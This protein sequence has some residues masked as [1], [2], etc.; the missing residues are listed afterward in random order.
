MC[1][2]A[3]II[4]LSKNSIPTHP[5]QVSILQK[6]LFSRGP[7]ASGLWQSTER[8]L[9]LVVQRLATKDARK[10][11]NQPCWSTDKKIISIFNGEIYNHKELRTKL[12][13]LG[14]KFY[15]KNDTEVIANAYH[16]WGETFLK[17]LRGQFALVVYDKI[18]QDLIIARD[19]DGISPLYAF[20]IGLTIFQL[21]QHNMKN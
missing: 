8:N 12:I 4:N 2:I 1:G 7:D 11:A 19:E 3:G 14:Y 18:K 16:Y 15:S 5:N 17:K 10:I 21:M 9:I 13:S 6:M 20:T